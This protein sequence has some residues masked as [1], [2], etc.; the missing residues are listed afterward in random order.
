MDWNFK[1][2]I[3]VTKLFQI[4]LFWQ[5]GT[6]LFIIRQNQN[7]YIYSF[8]VLKKGQFQNW[9]ILMHFITASKRN[10]YSWYQINPLHATIPQRNRKL[11]H[12]RNFRHRTTW[13]GS[14][15]QTDSTDNQLLPLRPSRS[16]KTANA[17]L[18]NSYSTTQIIMKKVLH[19]FCRR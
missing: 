1:I 8:T 5:K 2:Y 9:Y 4:A 16:L 6:H 3:Q 13:M 12:Y 18:D 11:S 19:I 7:M 10:F 14:N 17:D 15:F